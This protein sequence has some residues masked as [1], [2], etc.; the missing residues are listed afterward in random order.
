MADILRV[1]IAGPY[2]HGDQADNV[3]TAGLAALAV[4]KA[5]HAPF[6]PHL[7][8]FL[9]FLE[10]HSYVEWCALDLHWLRACHVVLRLPGHS[11]GSDREVDAAKQLGLPVYYTLAACL[12]ELPKV[13]RVAVSYGV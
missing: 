12:E 8:H 5:G 1:Y 3:R 4:M 13:E 9:H 7:F 11:P 10:P 2:S 6:C